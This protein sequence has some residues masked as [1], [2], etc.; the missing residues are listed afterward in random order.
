M[1]L[2]SPGGQPAATPRAIRSGVWLPS[3]TPITDGTVSVQVPD[4]IDLIGSDEDDVLAGDARA[5]TLRRR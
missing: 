2:H 5:N 4:I 1:R 3:V